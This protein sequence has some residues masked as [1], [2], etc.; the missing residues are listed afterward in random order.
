LPPLPGCHPACI[1]H[2]IGFY[3]FNSAPILSESISYFIKK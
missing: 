1:A 2:L 3:P